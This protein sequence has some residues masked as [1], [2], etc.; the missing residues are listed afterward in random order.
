MT[1]VVRINLRD[2]LAFP[3]GFLAPAP[4]ACVLFC[5]VP[6]EWLDGEELRSENLEAIYETMYGPQWREG[7]EDGSQYVVRSL[8]THVL[9]TDE[10]DSAPW[11]DVSNDNECQYW[12]YDA[13]SG[14]DIRSVKAAE[15]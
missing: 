2:G 15:L 10:E 14:V 4:Y 5:R 3:D 6:P 13:T 1:R 12:F 8:Q 7:N 9:T 11:R